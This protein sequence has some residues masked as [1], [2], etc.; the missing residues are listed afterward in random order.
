MISENPEATCLRRFSNEA[1]VPQP[2]LK[3]RYC[4][5]FFE[6]SAPLRAFG[7]IGFGWCERR[8]APIMLSA[9][10]LSMLSWAFT[11]AACAAYTGSN[12]TVANVNWGYGTVD[13]GALKYY[14]GLKRVV[15]QMPSSDG[16]LRGYDWKEGACG[17]SVTFES[18][19]AQSGSLLRGMP[20]VQCAACRA[21]ADRCIRL[22]ITSTIT[23]V[24]QI[25]T[26]LQRSTRYG[27]LNCQKAFG[28]TTSVYGGISAY[29]ALLRFR[30]GC[31]LKS[32]VPPWRKTSAVPVTIVL[33]GAQTS[34]DVYFRAGPGYI[35]LFLAVILKVF[36]AL[37]HFVV[38]T[39][40]S[41]QRPPPQ[42]ASGGTEAGGAEHDPY[43]RLADYMRTSVVDDGGGDTPEPAPDDAEVMLKMMED[44]RETPN[45]TPER[46]PFTN[47][48]EGTIKAKV[49]SSTKD[50]NP[51]PLQ[52]ANDRKEKFCPEVVS[53]PSS[54]ATPFTQVGSVELFL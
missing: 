24:F 49:A 19:S 33:T 10:A 5:T 50:E 3:R 4:R 54:A 35:L 27:D 32:S 20:V 13:G 7:A 26:D 43:E 37:A 40:T 2:C 36:D 18:K 47:S 42:V 29:F 1:T 30:H 34:V 31:G 52:T 48:E 16:A 39:P 17:E 9:F 28:F 14:V 25:T 12:D 41:R 11:L 53:Q 6:H 23:Q 44:E 45:A 21:V 51:N 15:F 22:A 46:D 38:P 8:R